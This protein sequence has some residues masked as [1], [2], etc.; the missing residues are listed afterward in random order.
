MKVEIFF[1]EITWP[2]VY[3]DC[4]DVDL[5]YLHINIVDVIATAGPQMI[6]VM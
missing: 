4:T 2:A 6:V 1:I 3:T 5:A